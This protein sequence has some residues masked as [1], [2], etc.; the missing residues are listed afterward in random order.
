LSD[1]TVGWSEVEE[2]RPATMKTTK[3]SYCDDF[4]IK[5]L[6]SGEGTRLMPN[7]ARIFFYLGTSRA[8]FFMAGVEKLF[9]RDSEPKSPAPSGF[10][11]STTGSSGEPTLV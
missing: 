9:R 8:E 5:F 2:R 11:A 4:K 6:F 10:V 3:Q 1:L 7:R